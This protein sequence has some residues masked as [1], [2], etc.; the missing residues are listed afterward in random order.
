MSGKKLA[1]HP[2]VVIIGVLAGLATVGGLAYTIGAN[3]NSGYSPGTEEVYSNT[4]NS[5]SQDSSINDIDGNSN[6]VTSGSNNNN[7]TTNSSNDNSPIN[8][9][10]EGNNS[11]SINNS[12]GDV[13]VNY[14]AVEEE[15]PEFTGA[16]TNG[17]VAEKFRKFTQENDNK[18][19]YIN[20][21][22]PMSAHRAEDRRDKI[23]VCTKD[24][25]S[26]SCDESGFRIL[27]ACSDPD[28][29]GVNPPCGGMNYKIKISEESNNLF[30]FT[31]GSYTI[32][33]YWVPQ[34]TPDLMYQGQMF[35]TL[36]A[37]RPQ[38]VR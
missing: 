32:K 24:A 36:S 31:S 2:A 33:G 26:S 27:Y 8:I 22:I 18:V 6:S 34:Y 10:S 35:S 19:V 4:N 9:Q 16:I 5:A 25:V 1:E 17:A 14:N 38:D 30:A 29:G 28:P 21:R 23:E 37:V 12:N 20:A 13:N 3:S 7:S 11:P 15:I